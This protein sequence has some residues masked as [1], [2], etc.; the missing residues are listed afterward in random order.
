MLAAVGALVAAIAA[1]IAFRE[2]KAAEASLAEVRR[3]TEIAE[4]A[5][6]ES[7]RQTDA[8]KRSADAAEESNRLASSHVTLVADR[9]DDDSDTYVLNNTG[10]LAATGVWVRR[11]YDSEVW[12]DAPIAIPPGERS[13]NLVA[14]FP[15]W[16]LEVYL[17]EKPGRIMIDRPPI[18]PLEH[19]AF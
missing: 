18:G 6:Q 2:A 7:A 10:N 13:P 3:Q 12:R 15:E 19:H 8:A 9:I 5:A 1:V 14:E 16:P 4:A 11:K 17:A